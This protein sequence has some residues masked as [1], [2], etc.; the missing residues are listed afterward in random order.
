[1]SRN[2][3][4]RLG[5]NTPQADPPLSGITNDSLA[6]AVPTEF[7]ELPSGGQYYT[8][9]H[10]LYKKDC[11]EIR[12]MTAKD[13]DILSSKVLLKKGLAID[14]FLNNVLI[15]KSINVDDLLVADKNAILVAARITGYGSDYNTKVICPHCLS[16]SEYEFDLSISNIDPGG[17]VDGFD[18]EVGEEG[19]FF[20]VAPKTE[21]RIECRP[22]FG[23][24]EKQLL[25]IS[26][27]RKRSKLPESSATTQLQ[28]I[29]KSVNGNADKG[30]IK[31][32]IDVM[33]AADARYIRKAYEQF[34]PSIELKQDFDC[35]ECSART[36][37]E[38]PFTSDFLWPK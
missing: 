32:F 12:Y 21:A 14:R 7:V 34:S 18:I 10:P 22:L 38:V 6:F 8:D 33:P 30:Y 31:S 16:R 1:M 2:N 24:D 20:I 27:R 36:V 35:P 28:F 17:T 9:E 15:D 29:I 5:T 26:E 4:D 37:L 23:K 13:E 3:L 19:A 11:I 25:A